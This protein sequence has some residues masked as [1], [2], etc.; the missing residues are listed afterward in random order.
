[1]KTLEQAIAVALGSMLCV[2]AADAATFVVT[3]SSQN[4]DAALARKI[5]AAGGRVT[6]RL[7]QI[8]VAVVES[9]DAN[10]QTRAGRVPG[11]FSVARDVQIQFDLPPTT[12]DYEEDFAN[13]PASGD[14]DT[15]FD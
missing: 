6:A 2:G 8:G 9:G 13:P 10:F 14:D 3:A 5:E 11:I 7:P 15:R 12:A 4:F 1:M